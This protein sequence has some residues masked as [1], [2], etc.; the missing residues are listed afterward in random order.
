MNNVNK[1][2]RK[3]FAPAAAPAPH[4]PT[5]ADHPEQ[6]REII[7]RLVK[8]EDLSR[9][10]AA[11]WSMETIK[12]IALFCATGMA[13]SFAA[14]QIQKISSPLWHSIAG[15]IFF[16]A[17]ALCIYRMHCTAILMK[18]IANDAKRRFE[19]VLWGGS[20]TLEDLFMSPESSAKFDSRWKWIY[21]MGW[22]ASGLSVVGTAFLL[23]PIIH[24]HFQA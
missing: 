24:L 19:G 17:F 1:Q 9:T 10:N 2:A 23:V 20:K 3:T 11:Q 14:M 12:H 16:I 4:K 18:D 5:I 8:S 13:G 6:A 7:H 21:A 15:G 22:T